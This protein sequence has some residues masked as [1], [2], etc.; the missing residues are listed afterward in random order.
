MAMK[1]NKRERW[2]V[3]GVGAAFVV[4]LLTLSNIYNPSP[5][6]TTPEQDAQLLA[7]KAETIRTEID[8]RNL[9]KLA[10][11]YEIAYKHSYN[12]AKALYFKS[13]VE[14]IIIAAGDR[15]EEI[16]REE[17]YLAGEVNKFKSTLNDVD[18]AWRM[19]LGT[20][21]EGVA[22]IVAND[23]QVAKL[24]AEIEALE[25]RKQELA[26]AAWSGAS[27]K[28]DE[29][30][31]KEIGK[32]E[33]S[34]VECNAKIKEVEHKSNIVKLAYRLQRGEELERPQLVEECC[35]CCCEDVE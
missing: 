1:S 22:I 25:L 10:Y 5:K 3:V 35:D 33:D 18:E 23:E 19:P 14:P 29:S 26:V 13:L 27:G 9:E 7:F 32:V 8:L 15:R 20:T 21:E 28:L 17:D 30:C 34:I 31:L 6:L 11:E 24:V 16:R 2:I 4:A 12:G